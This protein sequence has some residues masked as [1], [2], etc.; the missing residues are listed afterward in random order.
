MV[1]SGPMGLRNTQPPPITVDHTDSLPAAS[2]SHAWNVGQLQPASE[3]S[4]RSRRCGGSDHRTTTSK[5]STQQRVGMGPT[6]RIR[7]GHR[8]DTESS[9]GEEINYNT[10]EFAGLTHHQIS[11]KLWWNMARSKSMWRKHMHKPVTKTRR[12]FKKV[13]PQI[14]Q[15]KGKRQMGVTMP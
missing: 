7:G 15:P 14:R 13:F 12:F 1:H 5:P 2:A 9:L 10:P 4:N 3:H 11:E 8:F 6:G